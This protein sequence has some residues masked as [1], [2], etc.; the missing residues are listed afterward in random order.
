MGGTGMTNSRSPE[1]PDESA[2]QPPGPSSPDAHGGRWSR[3]ARD[4]NGAARQM[5]DQR[6][7]AHYRSL[8]RLGALLTGDMLVAEEVAAVAL[9]ASVSEPFG[10]RPDRA[11]LRLRRQVVLN[12]R[13]AMRPRRASA[14]GR[15]VQ[16]ASGIEQ[17][18]T[19]WTASPAIRFLGTLSTSQREAV[20]LRYYLDLSED[21]TAALMGATVRAV[22]RC[23]ASAMAAFGAVPP[24][25]SESYPSGAAPLA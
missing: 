12:T 15:P 23:L 21:E 6:Y 11:L 14:G 3:G 10:L 16:D 1:S 19:G 7:R 5:L 2:A 18:F 17:T 9:V 22:R 13:R 4:S 25:G 20:V 8:V 24:E